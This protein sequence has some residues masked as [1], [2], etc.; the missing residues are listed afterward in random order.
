MDSKRHILK[1]YV[2]K[3]IYVTADYVF[4]KKNRVNNL[5]NFLFHNV[6]LYDNPEI[7]FNPLLLL[8]IPTVFGGS[9]I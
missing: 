2:G 7:T 3:K 9:S 6:M 8:S 4:Y 1:Q 5:R